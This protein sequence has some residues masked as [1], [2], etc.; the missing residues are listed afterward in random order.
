[1]FVIFVVL[2]P[3]LFRW[4]QVLNKLCHLFY[5]LWHN[6]NPFIDLTSSYSRQLKCSV[7][8]YL[9][10]KVSINTQSLLFYN[11]NS[12]DVIKIFYPRE[13]CTNL[14]NKVHLINRSIIINSIKVSCKC[15]QCNSQLISIRLIRIKL[16]HIFCHVHTIFLKTESLQKS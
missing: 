13:N 4:G 14:Q 9:S 16:H 15:T 1:M 11:S 7:V 8:G 3:V 10:K 6:L 12:S 2:F 5:L